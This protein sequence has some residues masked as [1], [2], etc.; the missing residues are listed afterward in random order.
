M[1]RAVVLSLEFAVMCEAC[2]N[3]EGVSLSSFFV[4]VCVRLR[5]EEGVTV[6]DLIFVQFIY[7][8]QTSISVKSQFRYACIIS[9]DLYYCF[10]RRLHFPSI[11]DCSVAIP[12]CFPP[13]NCLVNMLCGM[14][15]HCGRDRIVFSTVFGIHRWP[16]WGPL[17]SCECSV[18]ELWSCHPQV[19]Q[20]NCPC[21]RVLELQ[22]DQLHGLYISL[23]TSYL[24]QNLLSFWFKEMLLNYLRFM[25]VLK[26]FIHL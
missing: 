8:D 21:S 3:V 4:C 6:G 15:R 12:F 2:Q 25:Q 10:D 16:V 5:T 26:H 9:Y 24:L 20:V 18:L 11:L 7:L 19:M 13:L 22:R 17:C 1:D 23:L 14:T